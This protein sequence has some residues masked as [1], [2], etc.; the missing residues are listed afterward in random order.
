MLE[1][2]RYPFIL[3]N[4]IR[5]G[6]GHISNKQALELFQKHRSPNLSHLFLSHLSY[7]NNCP[8]LV[9]EL[10]AVHAGN[11]KMIVT[12][13]KQESAVYTIAQLSR[14]QPNNFDTLVQQPQLAFSFD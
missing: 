4:R 11:V 13:R 7:N 6:F 5:N 10:F 2:G 1:K 14:L 3:K 12:S 8:K 9:E